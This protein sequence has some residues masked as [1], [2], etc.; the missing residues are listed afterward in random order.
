M[1][2]TGWLGPGLTETLDT[3]DLLAEAGISWIADWVLD[4]LPCRLATTHGQV[5]TMPYSVEHNDIPVV[6][7]QHH[8]TEEFARR[9]LASA[10]RLGAEAAR[11]GGTKVLSFAIHPYISGVPHRIAA[12]EGLLADLA[13]RDDVVFLQGRQI[14][15][16]Y[17]GTADPT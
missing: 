10:E 6:M 12:L 15:E 16:W 2:P 5:L 17:G 9:V 1:P 7:I 14:A 13:A 3:P 8:G 4:D 11:S